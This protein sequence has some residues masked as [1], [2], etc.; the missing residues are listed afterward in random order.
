LH[1]NFIIQ[2]IIINY[3]E[4]REEMKASTDEVTSH[5]Q[6]CLGDEALL[7]SKKIEEL[8]LIDQFDKALAVLKSFDKTLGGTGVFSSINKKLPGI[9]RAFS[10]VEFPFLTSHVRDLTRGMIQAACVYLEELIKKMSFNWFWEIAL[11]DKLPL[12]VLVKRIKHKIPVELYE[13]LNWLAQDVYNYAKH[14]FNLEKEGKEEPEHYFSV[15]D[16]VAVYFIVRKLG[17]EL[18]VQFFSPHAQGDLQSPE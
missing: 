5:L 14:H 6:S 15:F 11:P 12:G 7:V 3:G 13:E 16:A 10:Y 18:E 1:I 8:V 17:R 2:K 4:N 9:Y